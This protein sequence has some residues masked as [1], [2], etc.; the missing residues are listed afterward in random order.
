MNMLHFCCVAKEALCT[1]SYILQQ[2][3]KIC[4]RILIFLHSL[5]I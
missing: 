2:N 4:K 3:C 5:H 1:I